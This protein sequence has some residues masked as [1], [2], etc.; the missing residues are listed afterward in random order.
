MEFKIVVVYAK[1]VCF[2]VLLSGKVETE[3]A[4]NYL[5]CLETTSRPTLTH[6]LSRMDYIVL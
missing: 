3:M 1:E 5:G 2:C 4:N 6:F